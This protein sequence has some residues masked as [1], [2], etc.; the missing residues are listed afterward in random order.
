MANTT[1]VFALPDI[2]NKIVQKQALH[3]T[4]TLCDS[5]SMRQLV[6]APCATLNNY[7]LVI[8]QRQG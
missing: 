1:P 6:D 2:R 7:R 3:R 5:T 8:I 4:G